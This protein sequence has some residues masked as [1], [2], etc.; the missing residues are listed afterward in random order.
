MTFNNHTYSSF[1]CFFQL[2]RVE[3]IYRHLNCANPISTSMSGDV[4]SRM[5]LANRHTQKK[6][7][8]QWVKW[9]RKKESRLFAMI[10]H[11]IFTA[12]ITPL[13]FTDQHLS[14]TA[15]HICG[16]PS[17]TY[18]NTFSI[19]LSTVN[20]FSLRMCMVFEKK[21]F[22]F[23]F[24]PLVF[25]LP[26]KNVMPLPVSGDNWFSSVGLPAPYTMRSRLK[27]ALLSTRLV[28]EC[29]TSQMLF[30]WIEDW[31]PVK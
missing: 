19:L 1:F 13:I 5:G 12:A 18:T 20:V 21:A 29:S 9:L 27:I 14:I 8:G 31:N 24:C 7:I 10:D 15:W 26:T 11:D 30:N 4:K 3:T 25:S 23:T 6:F 17:Y 2:T 28:G 22:Y 16:L